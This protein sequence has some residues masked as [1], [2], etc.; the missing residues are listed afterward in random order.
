[1]KR[2]ILAVFSAMLFIPMAAMAAPLSDIGPYTGALKEEARGE[3]SFLFD[4]GFGRLVEFVRISEEDGTSLVIRQD[5]QV[6][7][8]MRCHV[9][10][11]TFS[12]VRRDRLGEIYFL[13]QLGGRQYRAF[14]DRDDHWQVREIME[15]EADKYLTVRKIIPL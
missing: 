15:N 3:S 2:Q 9:N 1:M 4:D 14:E 7:W 11:S 13:I 12:V 6:V 10:E 8:Q 5:R